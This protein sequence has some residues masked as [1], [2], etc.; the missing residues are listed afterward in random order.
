MKPVPLEISISGST[1][2]SGKGKGAPLWLD[3]LGLGN[4][5]A[6]DLETTGLTPG[7]NEIIEIGAIRFVDGRPSE[8]FERFVNPGKSLPSFIVQLTGITDHDVEDAPTFSDLHDELLAFIG[9]DPI[10][11]QSINF[12]LSF[13]SAAGGN[14]FRFPGRVVLDTGELARIFWA[15]FPRFSLGNLCQ[16][17][18]VELATAHR[19]GDD[20]QATGELLVEMI[21]N[22]P[23][24]VWADLTSQI[25]AL[26]GAAHHRGEV[27]FERLRLLAAD[28]PLPD[29]AP[30]DDERELLSEIKLDCLAE[31]G[32]FEASVEQF[33]PRRQQLDMAE[34]TQQAFDE[35]RVL[36]IEA[37]TGTG[38]SLGYLVPSLEWA[39]REGED[40][41]QRQVVISSHTRSL[42]EQ[43]LNQEIAA[44]GNAHSSRVPAA[45]LKGRD[46]YLCKRRLRSALTDLDGRLSDGDRMRLLPL[47]RWS[48]QTKRG[49]IGEIGGF[50]AETEPVLWSIVCSDTLGCAGARCGAHRGDFYRQ[51]LD[52][53]KSA[54][55][56]LVNHA[57]LATDFGRFIGGSADTK[58]L[59]IDEAHQFER[60]VVSAY[61]AVFSARAIRNVVSL[62]TDERAPRGL[63]MKLAREVGDDDYSAELALLDTA[64]KTTIQRARLAFQEAAAEVGGLA[65][66]ESKLRLRPNSSLHRLLETALVPVVEEL[67]DYAIRLDKLSQLLAKEDGLQKDTKDRIAELRSAVLNL[68]ELV[69]TGKRVVSADDSGHVYWLE[70][71]Q[72]RQAATASLFAAPISIAETLRHD[73]W[74]RVE[75]AVMTSATLAHEGAFEVTQSALG[76]ESHGSDRVQSKILDSPFDLE[77]Q[78][79]CYCPT[80]LPPPRE[81]DAHLTQVSGLLTFLLTEVQR[82]CLV[83]CTSHASSEALYRRLQPVARRAKRPLFQQ[84]GGRDTHEIVRAFRESGNGML[85]GSS[86]LWEGIDLVG[87]A[88]EVLMVVKLPFDVPT[89]PWV[90]ARGEMLQLQKQDPFSTFSVPSCVIRLRQGLGRL[91]RH[92]G[93]RG[94]AIIA[95]SRLTNTRYGRNMQAALPV[96]LRSVSSPDDLLNDIHSF[97]GIPHV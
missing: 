44:I 27:F 21:R 82:S 28:I 9:S 34:L 95:D 38:K 45:V 10:V 46:N 70:V 85:I 60:A 19:A 24:R 1:T 42:Q 20:A 84:T 22:L 55:L 81:S 59:V 52:Q 63:L 57:L 97:F 40:D 37:P 35:N 36:L 14:E 13:L 78:M 31:G 47:L 54:R 66:E 3:G 86:A 72:A 2:T 65:G 23:E 92:T 48:Y 93:D 80:Y 25:A 96:R 58:R 75:G 33:S 73:L 17:F 16:R 29:F 56:L 79:R 7:P 68:S 30:D 53:A 26:C 67:D 76:L 51:A 49:D 4:F 43:L 87:D 32:E 88:L 91:I 15:E 11:G 50:R 61:T 77:T 90:E 8:R 94:V 5:V 64:G 18:G 12:D 39:L 69:E 74:E 6:I 41:E 83:L 62:L 71:N 89:D